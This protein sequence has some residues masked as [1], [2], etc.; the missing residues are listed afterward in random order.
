MIPF[1]V[2]KKSE[3]ALDIQRD[4]VNFTSLLIDQAND[5]L[6]QNPVAFL[7]PLAEQVPSSRFHRE[8]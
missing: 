6:F 1:A 3:V 7:T 5:H 8:S 2:T 4:L